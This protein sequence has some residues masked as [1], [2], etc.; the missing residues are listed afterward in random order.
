MRV[1]FVTEPFAVEPLGIAYLAAALKKNG[2]EVDLLKIDNN[3][4]LEHVGEYKP[5]VV[6][7]SVTTGKHKKLLEVNRKIK[8]RYRVLSVFGGSHPTYFPELINERGVDVIIRGEADKSFPELLRDL[9]LK[10]SC[11]RVIQFRT[12]EQNIDRLPFPDREFLYKY[13]ENRNNPIKNVITSRGC[14]FS[15]PYC[16]NSLY[17]QFYE[18]Q[19]FVRFRSAENVVAECL[20]L[21]QYPTKFIFFQDDEFLSNPNFFPLMR[22]YGEKVGIPFHCQVRI[23]LVN[24]EKLKALKDAGC[25][26]VTFAVECG[27][28][29]KRRHLLL[30]GM[31]DDCILDGANLLHKYGLKIRTENMV[32][33]PG[34]NLSMMWE[35]VNLNK[36][37]RPT[38]AWASIFQ[39]Y[40]RLPL[41]EYARKFEF[42][43]GRDAF[44]ESFFE[45]TVLETTIRKEIINIQRLFGVL[46]HFQVPEWLFYQIIRIP[47]NKLF[48]KIYKKWKK[49]R[50]DRLFS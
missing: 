49:S 17:K 46:V 29:E 27:N 10:K 33:L 16:F 25:T 11:H 12:L 9:E 14:R 31:T 44:S 50:Y 47:N 42:W 8:E 4:F 6:A 2:H 28:W 48:D 3:G 23:E 5:D 21:K 15:C 45:D 30:R 19:N 41:G 35:T 22:L 7:Y 40:P 36:K 32:G 24:E 34:E 37:I 43:D 1:L 39:P 13:P 38:I 20:E 26:G 18:G